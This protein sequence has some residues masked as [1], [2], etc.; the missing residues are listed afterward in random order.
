MANTL[1]ADDLSVTAMLD[2]E[3]ATLAA[4]GVDVGYWLYSMRYYSEGLGLPLLPGFPDADETV[5]R[6]EELTG[7]VLAH[8]AFYELLAATRACCIVVRLM[9]LMVHAGM[10]PPDAD[11]VGNNPSTQLLSR[12]LGLAAPGGRPQDWAGLR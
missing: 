12:M 8:R 9:N 3:E 2:W 5:A 11:L 6:Y 10:L 1:I 7:R 4:P